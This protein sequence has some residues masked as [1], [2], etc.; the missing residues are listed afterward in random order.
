MGRDSWNDR[1]SG[2]DL[3]RSKISPATLVMVITAAL[4]AATVGALVLDEVGLFRGRREAVR[5]FQRMTGGLGLGAT[6]CPRWCFVNFDPRLERCT[7]A[8]QPLPGGYCYCPEHGGTV[9]FFDVPRPNVAD[10]GQTE[11]RGP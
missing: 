10:A 4:V 2:G 7:C 9:S 1:V 5:Q 8:E 3:W 6:V 11:S